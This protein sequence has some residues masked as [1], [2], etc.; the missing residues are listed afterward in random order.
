M[1]R[2]DPPTAE[3]VDA[4]DYWETCDYVKKIVE[5]AHVYHDLYF[6]PRE[7]ANCE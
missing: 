4:I 5:S 3:R 1:P 6:S 7:A 2:R